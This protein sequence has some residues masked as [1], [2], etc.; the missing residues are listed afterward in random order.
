MIEK[1]ATQDTKTT[2]MDAKTATWFYSLMTSNR[3][4]YS[5]RHQLNWKETQKRLEGVKD[6]LG[7]FFVI[8]K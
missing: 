7:R 6:E 4:V 8:E 2:S 5:C 3:H 1:T